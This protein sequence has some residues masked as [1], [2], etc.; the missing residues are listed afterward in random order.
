MVYFVEMNENNRPHHVKCRSAGSTEEHSIFI[1]DD[2]T[3][4]ID[5]NVSKDGKFLFINSGTK[6]DSEIWVIKDKEPELLIS[7]TPEVRVH[8]EH[9]RDFFLIISNNEQGSKNFKL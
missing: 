2:P 5:I 1:D 3:H 6:E 9:I 7:R 4:Y 8:I